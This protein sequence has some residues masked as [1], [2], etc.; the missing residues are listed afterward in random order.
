MENDLE[1][2]NEI[3]NF[4][5]TRNDLNPFKLH[6]EISSQ[7]IN[8][9]R[10]AYK[11]IMNNDFRLKIFGYSSNAMRTHY[12][13]KGEDN[14]LYVVHKAY[15]ELNDAFYLTEGNLSHW[16]DGFENEMPE[17]KLSD[18]VRNFLHS[19]EE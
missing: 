5:N 9:A 2:I 13:Y 1:L 6:A 16:F 17:F 10:N 14:T 3:S 12:L 18:K 4:V 8:V 15:G 11:D 19:L 7:Y